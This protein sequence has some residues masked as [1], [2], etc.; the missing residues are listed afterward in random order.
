MFFFA[1]R[2]NFYQDQASYN[3]TLLTR[4]EV[5]L[6]PF[7]ID[8]YKLPAAEYPNNKTTAIVTNGSG[9]RQKASYFKVWLMCRVINHNTQTEVLNL[10]RLHL[11]GFQISSPST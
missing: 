8:H 3:A 11:Q 6:S 10:M 9:K 7:H 2:E 5:S 1:L 4:V